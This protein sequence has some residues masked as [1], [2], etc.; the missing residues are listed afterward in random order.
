MYSLSRTVGPSVPQSVDT[1]WSGEPLKYWNSR[2]TPSPRSVVVA[3][4]FPPNHIQDPTESENICLLP[5]SAS[6]CF[7]MAK[8]SCCTAAIFSIDSSKKLYKESSE[9]ELTA[10]VQANC[11]DSHQWVQLCCKPDSLSSDHNNMENS[12][13]FLYFDS[14]IQQIKLLSLPVNHKIKWQS[15]CTHSNTSETLGVLLVVVTK[16]AELIVQSILFSRTSASEQFQLS[17]LIEVRKKSC[18]V[19]VRSHTPTKTH[20]SHSPR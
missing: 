14:E 19:T 18:L 3:P 9:A 20:C 1:P 2:H 10:F 13:S 6:S 17:E 11:S 16:R 7:T 4:F 12:K 15:E 5:K 8:D